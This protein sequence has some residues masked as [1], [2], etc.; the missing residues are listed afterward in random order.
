MPWCSSYPGTNIWLT[1]R[2]PRKPS[3]EPKK[4]DQVDDFEVAFASDARFQDALSF[5]CKRQIPKI[6][7]R[8]ANT[9]CTHVPLHFVPKRIAAQTVA[10]EAW[11]AHCCSL[12][13]CA[14][15]LCCSILCAKTLENAR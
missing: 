9:T 13:T 11:T 2:Q 6:R 7:L 5:R 1:F 3:F 8:N 10:I 14:N 12:A 4:H 15:R